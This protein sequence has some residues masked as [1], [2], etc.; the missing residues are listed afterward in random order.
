MAGG[1]G[2]DLITGDPGGVV[3]TVG[4]KANVVLVLDISQSMTSDISFGGGTIQRIEAMEDA[5]KAL[6]D[7]LAASGAEDVRV[8]IVK[9]GINGATVGTYDVRVDGVAMSASALNTIK[10]TTIENLSSG[11][12]N[13]TNYEA[14][15]WQAY[16]WINGSGPLADANVN[17]LLFISDGEPNAWMTGEHGAS[18]SPSGPTFNQDALDHITAT[19][20][21]SDERKLIEQHPNFTTSPFTIE[22]IG[23]S[24]SGTALTRL[25]TVEDGTSATSIN[26]AE[27]LT[28]AV[29]ALAGGSEVPNTAG[30]DV[31]NGG[32]GADIIFG[33][34]VF[35]D[36]LAEAVGLGG[37]ITPDGS[38]WAVFQKLESGLGT[39][40]PDPAGNGAAW[41][42]DD[43]IAYIK[44]NHV[45]LSG[46][47]GRSGGNDTIDSGNG[48]D[49][50]YGQEG[51]DTI[52]GGAGD[53]TI[54]GG[55]GNDVIT[56]GT[57][58]DTMT[59]GSGADTFIIAAGHATPT[60]GGTGNGGTIAG[61][62]KIADFVSAG[63]SA[64]KID[65]SVAPVAAANGNV[66]GSG[67]STL[68]IVGDT[69]KSH[70]VNATSGL[71]T[72]FGT[73]GFATT[74]SVTN[75]AGLAAVTQYLLGS[76]IGN[77]GATLAFTAMGNT[78]IYQQTT[79]SAGGTLV[80]LTGVT[81]ANVNTLLGAGNRI[82]PI[83]LDLN[84]NG[85]LFSTLA[86]GVSFDIDG[87]G[88]K[89]QLA[90]NS[91]RDG[92]L[93]YDRDGDGVID[94]GTELFSPWFNGG[95]FASG[96]EALASLDS[97]GDGV[98]DVR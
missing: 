63:G 58:G 33:D 46:E 10:T 6:L 2:D 39:G 48:N 40:V 66:D 90:W 7:Q 32:D 29:G 73:D 19:D 56:G 53:D 64:D 34:V 44:A 11:L 5:V 72:F 65:F 60:I 28:Q 25:G 54:N 1:A 8:H 62:D 98:V 76:D 3:L 38:G 79:T 69:V 78:Y 36:A 75:A 35:T 13:G 97:N 59:G 17:K 23:I 80:E 26:S 21:A 14:G 18:N 92:I 49:I 31:I 88:A 27:Q 77:A 95:D 81:I 45:A 22:A 50:I 51:V 87:D 83:V 37:S 74:L 52:S 20:D 70:N 91:S 96:G 12:E 68:T 47:S 67:N 82:D 55:S 15:L 61:Y 42:R 4:D 57:G 84:N 16:Q 94:D 93:A 85:F 24:L 30:S 41:N 86:A 89:D 43:T 9:F 71:A